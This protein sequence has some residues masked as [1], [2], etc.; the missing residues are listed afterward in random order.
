MQILTY[1]EKQWLGRVLGLGVVRPQDPGV[2]LHLQENVHCVIIVGLPRRRKDRARHFREFW[3]LV[4]VGV[5][6]RVRIDI[7]QEFDS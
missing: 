6:H 5:V 1:L 3:V 7:L 4:L 2:G